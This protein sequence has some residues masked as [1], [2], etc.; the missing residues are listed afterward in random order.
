MAISAEI[1]DQDQDT[2][3]VGCK[4]ENG[5]REIIPLDRS[6]KDNARR[7][8]ESYMPTFSYEVEGA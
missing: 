5:S 1:K 2:R 6:P 7:V 3:P 8:G 4:R